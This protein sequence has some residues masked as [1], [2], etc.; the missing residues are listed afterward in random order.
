[1][2]LEH[3]SFGYYFDKNYDKALETVEK[4]YGL[5]PF[6]PLAKLVEG[7]LLFEKKDYS[8]A[9]DVLRESK[10]G[11]LGLSAFH[12]ALAL[13]S[14]GLIYVQQG[15]QDEALSVINE[16]TKFGG[17]DGI[18]S[19][20][21]IIHLYLGNTDKG[22]NTINKGVVDQNPYIYLKVDPKL[23]QYRNEAEFKKLIKL[24]NLS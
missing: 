12:E 8:S 19:L 4:T 10:K 2:A 11:F 3:L 21:G 20:K 22:Y 9:L 5:T 16:L 6:A 15:K 13:Y 18:E 14:Q 23:D 24:F 1:M 17:A 7:W